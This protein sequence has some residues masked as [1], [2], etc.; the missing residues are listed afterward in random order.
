MTGISIRMVGADPDWG[1]V[2]LS[3]AG[4]E[5]VCRLNPPGSSPH[6]RCSSCGPAQDVNAC[7][8]LQIASLARTL[9]LTDEPS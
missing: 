1:P 2:V 4:R 5:I 7:A 8:H 6:Y 9:L 3:I